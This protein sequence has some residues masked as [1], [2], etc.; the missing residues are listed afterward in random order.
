MFCELKYESI[1]FAARPSTVSAITYMS[2][3]INEFIRNKKLSRS[4]FEWG[5]SN[6]HILRIAVAVNMCIN[7][8]EPDLEE[9]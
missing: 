8:A 1:I 6:V 9:I 7:S 4:A 3:Q 5:I 2:E